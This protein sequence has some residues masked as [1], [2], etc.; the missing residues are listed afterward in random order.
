MLNVLHQFVIAKD[1]CDAD[2]HHAIVLHSVI[3]T[4]AAILSNF[5]AD[6]L[7]AQVG[8]LIFPHPKSSLAAHH[9]HHSLMKACHKYSFKTS[10]Q[11]NDPN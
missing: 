8:D 7:L 4:S 3:R 2:A 11:H 6:F 10:N 1:S 5:I 9:V